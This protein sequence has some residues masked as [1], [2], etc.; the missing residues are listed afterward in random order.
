MST[1]WRFT[2]IYSKAHKSQRQLRWDPSTHRPLRIVFSCTLLYCLIQAIKYRFVLLLVFFRKYDFYTETEKII[3]FYFPENIIKLKRRH[4]TASRFSSLKQ[5]K[6]K[7]KNCFIVGKALLCQQHVA[8]VGSSTLSK[9]ATKKS[10]NV[11]RA[12][13]VH[14]WAIWQ[15]ADFVKVAVRSVMWPGVAKPVERWKKKNTW[16]N[17]NIRNMIKETSMTSMMNLNLPVLLT[18]AVFF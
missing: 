7:M 8:H 4:I 12:P 18:D 1:H 15:L 14:H 10:G 11:Q 5:R 2:Y 3:D 9:A 6:I 13:K 17:L 16:Q